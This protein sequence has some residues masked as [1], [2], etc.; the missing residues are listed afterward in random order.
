MENLS[1]KKVLPLH[2]T[3][4]YTNSPQGTVKLGEVIS[5]SLRRGGGVL[6]SG[7][8]GTG[9]TTLIS[10][11][12][13]GLQVKNKVKSP[14]FVLVWLYEGVVPIYHIDLYRLESYEELEEIGWE[15]MAEEGKIYLVEWA[16]KFY[17]PF[18]Q[19]AIKIDI[20]SGKDIESRE[21]EISFDPSI[22]PHLREDLENYVKSHS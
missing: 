2:K 22:F 21:I 9:K 1:C 16:D 7:D 5:F 13:Q 10:G 8:L 6:L 18:T 17:I 4:I 12:C 11:I 3:V 19:N 20:K 14:T 15:E